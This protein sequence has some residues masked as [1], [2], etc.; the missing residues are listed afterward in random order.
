[1]VLDMLLSKKIRWSNSRIVAG[2]AMMSLI[3]LASSASAD[4][5][6]ALLKINGNEQTSGIGNNCWKVENETFS[7]CTDYAGIITQIEPLLTKSPFIANLRLP[8]QEPPE[9]LGYMARKVTDENELK[10]EAKGARVWVFE[11]SEGNWYK[12]PSERESDINLSLEPGLYVLDVG[13]EWKEKGSTT[14][15]FLVQVYDP[16]AKI[17]NKVSSGEK[18][19]GFEVILAIATLLLVIRFRRNRKK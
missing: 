14:Y 6:P 10:S 3:L 4:P 5:P 2:M 9:E 7:L 16:E 11:G 13:A 8:L 12:L 15:G 19:V 18:V 1:M 17:T